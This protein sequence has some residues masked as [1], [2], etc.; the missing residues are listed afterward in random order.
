MFKYE[1]LSLKCDDLARVQFTEIIII[2]V[3]S[4]IYSKHF[5]GY[6]TILRNHGVAVIRFAVTSS[7]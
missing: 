3:S 2:P 7:H 5:T 1:G 6:L 4:G